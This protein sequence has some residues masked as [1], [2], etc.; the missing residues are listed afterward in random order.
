MAAKR[1][2]VNL[3]DEVLAGFGW[4]EDEVPSKLRETLVMDL[5]RLG[6][7]SEAQTAEL[8]DLDRWQLLEVMGRHRV[9]AVQMTVEELRREIA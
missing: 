7:L 9:P 5:L 4:R 3:P 6:Q 8:L 2:K 1:F